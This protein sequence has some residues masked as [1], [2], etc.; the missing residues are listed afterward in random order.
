MLSLLLSYWPIEKELIDVSQLSIIFFTVF[1][2]VIFLLAK[3][4][5]DSPDKFAFNNIIILSVGAKMIVSL[6]FL[7][8]YK[9]L[10]NPLS[11]YFVVPFLII[12][13]VYTIFE[14]YFMTLLSNPKKKNT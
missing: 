8:I 1:S 7:L 6:S 3:R 10:V 13:I 2:V 14:T 12:Y 9:K 11:H 5:V 4:S